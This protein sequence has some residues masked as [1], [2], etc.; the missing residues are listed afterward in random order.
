MSIIGIDLGTSNSCVA[1]YHHGS[2]EII[3]NNETGS[4]ITP[5]IVGFSGDERLIG[6][7]AKAQSAGNPKN[8]IYEIKRL[9]GRHFNDHEVQESIKRVPYK[10]INKGGKP[11]VEVEFKGETKQFTP[12]EISAMILGKMKEIAEN[13]LGHEVTDCIIT[14]PA[15]ADNSFREATKNAGL[16]AGFKKIQRI[17]NE[18]TSAALAYGL[19][20]SK[21]NEHKILIVDSGGGTTDF[22]LLILDDGMFEVKATLGDRFLGGS[23]VDN[24]LM[25]FCIKDFKR[26]HKKDLNTSAKAVKRLK[27][28]CE[29]AKKILSTTTSAKIEIDALFEG[30]DYSVNMSRAKYESLCGGLFKKIMGFIDRVL[31]DAEVDRGEVDDIVLVGGSTRIP[32]IRQ[33]LTAYFGGKKLYT[34]INPDECVAH[35]AAVQGAILG[36]VEDEKL[37]ILLLDVNPLSLGLE[38]AGGIMTKLIPRNTTIPTDKD[39]VFSTYAHNQT[40]VLIQIYEGER[41]LT[42][43][44]RLLGK[45]YLEGIPPAPRGIPKI[46]VTFNV[47]AD[48]ILNVTAEDMGTKNKNSITITHDKDRLSSED[49]ERM[50]SEAEKYKEEDEKIRERIN[51]RNTLETYVY[52]VENALSEE[53]FINASSEEDRA[54]IGAKCTE[55]LE[56]LE[57][58]VDLDKEVCEEKRAELDKLY[59]PVI[60]EI[61]KKSNDPQFDGEMY[62]E[63]SAEEV[64]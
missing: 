9:M 30:I 2:V 8:T 45:F 27:I 25:E 56:W 32:K 17:I 50:I 3:A 48:G 7:P 57:E 20:K 61:Y 53:R 59:T 16:I 64:D 18:P 40:G 34:S 19:E 60:M 55:L 36:G 12:E 21:E 38:T 41:D 13:Y 42:R 58:N 15:F 44:N 11:V 37:D 39:M 14:V 4:R 22:T 46:K 62:K 49:I 24:I 35:G 33:M 31:L 10:I 28:G 6:E 54:T 29:R 5:S 23:D 43:D 26:K 1:V 63:E 47:D 52:N 51:A